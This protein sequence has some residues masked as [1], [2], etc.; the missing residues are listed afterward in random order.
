MFQAEA[1]KVAIL[2]KLLQDIPKSGAWRGIVESDQYTFYS[3]GVGEEEPS[4]SLSINLAKGTIARRDEYWELS[5]SRAPAWLVETLGEKYSGCPLS[6]TCRAVRELLYQ[7]ECF[8]L[9]K[10]W[11]VDTANTTFITYPDSNAMA[12]TASVYT[13]SGLPSI[14]FIGQ[15]EVLTGR[16]GIDQVKFTLRQGT[17]TREIIITSEDQGAPDETSLKIVS[18]FFGIPAGQRQ[19]QRIGKFLIKKIR[20]LIASAPFSSLLET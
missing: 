14:S 13:A 6:F 11:E 8:R 15:A 7:S 20:T 17:K 1:E 12:Y 2:Y 9:E 3:G 16:N 19:T 4:N 18:E 10:I 5:L